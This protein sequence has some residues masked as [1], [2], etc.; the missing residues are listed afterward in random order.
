VL[1]FSPTTIYLF[2]VHY[3]VQ[4]I[5]GGKTSKQSEPLVFIVKDSQK[6]DSETPTYR[7]IV[8]QTDNG[9]NLYTH[10]WTGV[11]TLWDAFL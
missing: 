5:M 8:C 7:N 11:N 6:R 1:S 4:Y 9:G 2:V 10:Y 3:K